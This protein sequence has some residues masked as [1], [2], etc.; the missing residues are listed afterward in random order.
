MKQLKGFFAQKKGGCVECGGGE[1]VQNWRMN[2]FRLYFQCHMGGA[3]IVTY[4]PLWKT[5]KAK[6]YSK[7]FLKKNGIDGKIMAR[8]N[9]GEAI[10]MITLERICRIVG[11]GASDVLD[12]IIVEG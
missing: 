10:S 6:G 2:L 8:M 1:H 9:H 4:D 5:L 11:C 3:A 7:S 12:F